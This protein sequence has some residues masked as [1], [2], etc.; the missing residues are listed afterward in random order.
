[1]ADN[2]GVKVAACPI[3]Q[4]YCYPSC[5]Y[6]RGDRCQFLSKLGRQIP[7]LKRKEGGDA[8]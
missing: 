5:Y 2:K 3:K 8:D 7:E 1:M 4:Q 6:R